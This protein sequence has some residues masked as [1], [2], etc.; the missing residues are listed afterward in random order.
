M[1]ASLAILNQT[2]K[3]RFLKCLYNEYWNLFDSTTLSLAF[4]II[5]SHN[6][7]PL[8]F[9][10]QSPSLSNKHC[11]STFIVDPPVYYF[12]LQK[13]LHSTKKLLTLKYLCGH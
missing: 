5:N 7:C 10:F 2:S 4:W 6:I 1:T 12:L 9:G 3:Q 13:I 8:L 11:I